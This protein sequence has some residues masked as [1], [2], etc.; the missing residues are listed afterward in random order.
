MV[1]FTRT[2][3]TTLI[4]SKPRT[5]TQME[6]DPIFTVKPNKVSP[7]QPQGTKSSAGLKLIPTTATSMMPRK[8]NRR[9]KNKKRFKEK[10][11]RK[12]DKTQKPQEWKKKIRAP[13]HFTY[14]LDDY[15][16]PQCA[17]NKRL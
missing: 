15:C 7:L 6:N 16:P 17:C 11:R 13:T 10:K 3:S 9:S 5:V 8:T 1:H 2:P 14:F 12:D 4:P